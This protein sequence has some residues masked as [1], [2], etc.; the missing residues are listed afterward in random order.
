[1]TICEGDIFKSDAQTLVNTVNCVGVM[2]KGIALGFRKRFLDMH[3]DYVRRCERGEVKLG[4]PYLYKRPKHPWILNFPTKDHWRSMSRLA[5][6]EAGL[7]YLKA[8]YLEWGIESLAVPPLGSG[9]GGLEWQV[10][11]PTLY[12][13]LERLDIPVELYV[14]FGTPHDELRP[15]HFQNSLMAES[16]PEFGRIGPDWVAL[17]T[18]LDRLE[19]QTYRPRIGRTSFQKLAYFATVEGLE[20]GLNYSRSSYGPYA[21]ELK[22]YV[23]HL[24][25]N[26]LIQETRHGR[27]FEVRLGTTYE[28]AKRAFTQELVDFEPRVE[29]LV[30]LFARMT[31]KDAEVA[32][33]VH[34][35]TKELTGESSARPSE[36]QIVE[37]VMRWK[38][39]RRPP[40]TEADVSQAVRGL[41]LL[42]WIEAQP[43]EDLAADPELQAIPS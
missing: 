4:Q 33:T 37:A 17:L 1:M 28:A 7:E 27:M 2:G 41:N 39:Q 13:H 21:P 14:P 16:A 25:N 20:L 22:H 40:L 31:T 36:Q 9:L 5:D 24:L 15:A 26:G 10:V 32:A 3:D 18:V 19:G 42:G 30:D 34:F 38:Q 23:S 29:R 12:S 8:H 35:A 43:T 6:I 11:G